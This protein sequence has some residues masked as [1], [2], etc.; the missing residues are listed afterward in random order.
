MQ[1]LTYPLDYEI[2][3]IPNKKCVVPNTGNA[4]VVKGRKQ[5]QRMK[6][7]HVCTR[8]M[9]MYCGL[10]AERVHPCCWLLMEA[11]RCCVVDVAALVGCVVDN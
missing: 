11:V 1:L 2:P 4:L 5:S 6:L 10:V 9:N 7:L 3:L 8:Y